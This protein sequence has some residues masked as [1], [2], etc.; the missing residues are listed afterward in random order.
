[1]KSG[2]PRFDLKLP[3]NEKQKYH[4]VERVPNFT[5]KKGKSVK[6]IV[7][8]VMYK[9]LLVIYALFRLYRGANLLLGDI[10]T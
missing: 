2:F 5:R 8:Q 10:G 1:M 4:I 6:L 3:W 9:N 7:I